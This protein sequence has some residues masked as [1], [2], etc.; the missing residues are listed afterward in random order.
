[1]NLRVAGHDGLGEMVTS[2]SK[3]QERERNEPTVGPKS[4]V[5]ERGTGGIPRVVRDKLSLK[6]TATAPKMWFEHLLLCEETKYRQENWRGIYTPIKGWGRD[7]GVVN[8]AGHDLSES[9]PCH[10]DVA[11]G[12][13][14]AKSGLCA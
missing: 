4:T 7:R 2:G 6:S 8:G 11:F 13:V 9:W 10:G 5:D 12:V 14:N 1:M 3:R